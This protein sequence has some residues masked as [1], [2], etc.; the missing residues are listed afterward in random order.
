MEAVELKLHTFLTLAK[1]TVEWSTSHR[2]EAWIYSSTH[3]Y[4]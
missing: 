2:M 4:S 3:S 1:D